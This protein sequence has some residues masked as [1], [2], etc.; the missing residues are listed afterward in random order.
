ML[1]TQF[2]SGLDNGK[3]TFSDQSN[4]LNEGFNNTRSRALQTLVGFA[5]WLRE[6]DSASGVPE[7]ITILEKRFTPQAEYPVTLPEYAI[8]G[9][10][11]PGIFNLN[12]EW[13]I[14]H[15][16]DFFPQD[17]LSEWLAAFSSF[18]CYNNPFK[19]TFEIFRD[20]FDFALQHL[21]DSK[22]NTSLG[23]NGLIPSA[24][25][26]SATICGEMYPLKGIGRNRQ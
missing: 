5:L 20:D 8:L 12:K 19:L 22:I 6:H 14:E 9:M 7:V 3:R 17:K 16:S 26:C 1:C 25:T 4:L 15:K 11:Y 23:K 18:I 21:T 13:A 10:L 24:N 2:D